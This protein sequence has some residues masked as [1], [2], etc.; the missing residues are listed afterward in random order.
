M[1]LLC[2][3]NFMKCNMKLTDLQKGRNGNFR[4]LEA[5]ESKNML[6]TV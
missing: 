1:K 6:D 4:H 2:K 3:M 5:Q